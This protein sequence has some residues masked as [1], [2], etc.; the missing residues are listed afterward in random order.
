MRLRD[1]DPSQDWR[2]WLV[3]SACGYEV[4]ALAT[5]KVP[6]L[7]HLAWRARTHKV[8]RIVLWLALGWLLDHVLGEGREG[9]VSAGLASTDTER[10]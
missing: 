4:F 9:L 7:T 6:A 3:G 2:A 5:G 1:L 10:T 8:W